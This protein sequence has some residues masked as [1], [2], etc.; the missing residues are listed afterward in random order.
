MGDLM[1]PDV[2]KALADLESL[3]ALAEG[4]DRVEAADIEAVINILNPPKPP[5][6]EEPGHDYF[7]GSSDDLELDLKI[8]ETPLQ[9]DTRE[10][11]MDAKILKT[12]QSSR[13]EGDLYRSKDGWVR[14]LKIDS[15][16][17]QG[18]KFP[19]GGHGCAPPKTNCP[20]YADGPL[21]HF[22]IKPGTQGEKKPKDALGLGPY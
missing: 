22:L 20:E 12:P 1:E 4:G 17:T 6:P 14:Q 2:K 11:P 10:Y 18:D 15:H 3:K 5:L 19:K 9:F 16:D 21:Q 7:R 8:D 13:F